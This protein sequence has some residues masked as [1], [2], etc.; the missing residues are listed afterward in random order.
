MQTN[1]AEAQASVSILQ[2]VTQNESSV[3]QKITNHTGKAVKDNIEP[4]KVYFLPI[5]EQIKLHDAM[6]PLKSVWGGIKAGSFGYIFGPSK[7]GK[8]ILCENLGLSIASGRKDFMGI[9]I[10]VEQQKVLFVSLEEFWNFRAGRNKTQVAA[11][12]CQG[13]KD[14]EANYLVINDGFPRYLMTTK[15]W[16]LLEQTISQSGS[17]IVFID[18]LTRMVDGQIEDSKEASTVSQQLRDMAYKLGITMVVIHHTRKQNG[19][20][21]GIDSL[22]GSRVLSQEAD[23][24]IGISKTPNGTRYMKEVAFRYQQ[25]NDETVTTFKINNECWIEKGFAI[26]EQLILQTPESDGRRDDSNM[27]KV[28]EEIIRLAGEKNDTVTTEAIY[29]AFL[30]TGLMTKPTIHDAIDKLIAMKEIVKVKKG[31]Y[32]LKK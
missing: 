32:Q 29:N 9:P 26:N 18:S 23:F 24:M 2:V 6:P 11:L 1:N 17:K 13:L 14:F 22:A 31:I 20:A 10:E 28:R 7:S 12:K 16:S 21:M 25:E 3:T 19:Q 5:N 4:H 30:K 15:D 27:K 8:T